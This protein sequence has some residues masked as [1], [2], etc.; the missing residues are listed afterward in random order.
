M[1][2][3]AKDSTLFEVT[4]ENVLMT[5]VLQYLNMVFIIQVTRQHAKLYKSQ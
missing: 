5:A 1:T 3:S 4:C 2:A